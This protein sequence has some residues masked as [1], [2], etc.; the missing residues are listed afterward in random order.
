MHTMFIRHLTWVLWLWF[1][2]F[3][4]IYSDKPDLNWWAEFS[5]LDSPTVLAATSLSGK[6]GDPTLSLKIGS[7]LKRQVNEMKKVGYAPSLMLID[8]VTKH[9]GTVLINRDGRW[10]T[11][12]DDHWTLK[13]ANVVC[14]MLG[15]PH[16]LQATTR[17][18]FFSSGDSES[19]NRLVAYWD[20]CVGHPSIFQV[21]SST[22]FALLPIENAVSLE[23][24]AYF[25]RQT[26]DR[27]PRTPEE[28]CCVST[29]M[30]NFSRLASICER[31]SHEIDVVYRQFLLRQQLDKRRWKL[32]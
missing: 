15:F 8:G 10:G 6:H 30:L 1:I 3:D 9:E 14:R 29:I 11:I 26:G 20:L 18:Y 13:E 21:T 24:T 12:C 17:D 22:A 23:K 2:F 28:Q 31:Y 4:V 25:I 5:N 19:C 27:P 16:A 7:G 32:A